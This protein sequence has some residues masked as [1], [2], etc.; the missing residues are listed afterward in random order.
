MGYQCEIIDPASTVMIVVDMQND[1]V[2]EGAKLRSAQAAA[3]VPLLAQTLKTCRD[4]GIRVIYTAHVHRRDGSDMGLYDDLYSPIADRS[5][6]VDG[7]EGVQIFNDLAPAPG[8]HVIKKHRYSAFFATDL[9]LILREWGITTVIIS[10]TTTENCCHAT[11]RDAMFHNYKVVFLSD[12][13]GTFD[14]P[15]VG[16]GALSAEEVHRATLTILAFS[17]AHVMT[18]AEMLGRVKA[19]DGAAKAA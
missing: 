14:Y 5:S 11:A 2:A 10:G 4:K 16:Q 9:D 19:G 8:E 1:F 6:L 17:T 18:A 3:M 7:T 12:A 13:T 15:D